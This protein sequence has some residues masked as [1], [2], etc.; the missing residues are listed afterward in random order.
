MQATAFIRTDANAGPVSAHSVCEAPF[1]AEESDFSPT[2][3]PRRGSW[4]TNVT[5]SIGL[6]TA[7]ALGLYCVW[8]VWHILSYSS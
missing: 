5:I 2:F 8:Q 3:S 4:M 7:G 1:F 6:G